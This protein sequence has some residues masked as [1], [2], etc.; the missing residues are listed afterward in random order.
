MANIKDLE[1][2][3]SQ[4]PH[5]GE[6]VMKILMRNPKDR[7]FIIEKLLIYLK[8]N[9]EVQVLSIRNIE[10]EPESNLRFMLQVRFKC[11]SCKKISTEETN[12]IC[13]WH[14][15]QSSYRPMCEMCREEAQEYAR[16]AAEDYWQAEKE[17]EERLKREAEIPVI[18]EKVNQNHEQKGKE[19]SK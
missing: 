2:F 17:E 19:D 13:F 3:E 18:E 10:N 7:D 9:P 15:G 8:A 12:L 11:R 1:Q 4:L 14:A 6:L 16:E 5:Y